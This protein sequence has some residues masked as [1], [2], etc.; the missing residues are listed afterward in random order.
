MHVVLAG[1]VS[2][3]LLLGPP[4][5]KGPKKNQKKGGVT[6]EQVG[7]FTKEQREKYGAWATRRGCPPGLARKG[8]GCLPPGQAK[9][10]WTMG[11]PLPSGV[12]WEAVPPEVLVYLDPVPRGHQYVMVDGDVLELAVGSRLVLDALQTILD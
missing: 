6:A 12:R 3:A 8:N 1:A 7:G 11:K 4:P 9:K 10:R 5:G 2:L